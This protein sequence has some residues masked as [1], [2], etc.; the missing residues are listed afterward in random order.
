MKTN[1]SPL[2][3]KIVS[4]S[5]QSLY[6]PAEAPFAALSLQDRGSRFFFGVYSIGFTAAGE[7]LQVFVSS[8]LDTTLRVRAQRK[9]GPPL[10]GINSVSFHLHTCYLNC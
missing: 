7:L 3:W 2:K 4:R 10:D 6:D 9:T 8:R 5:A 1:L